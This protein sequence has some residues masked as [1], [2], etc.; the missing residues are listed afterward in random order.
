MDVI[1][2]S[3]SYRT[4]A[5][6]VNAGFTGTVSADHAADTE[7]RQ[8]N[9][10]LTSLNDVV[11]QDFYTSF[12]KVPLIASYGV[13]A[14]ELTRSISP[15]R[16]V[17]V[18]DLVT[19][20]FDST[21]PVAG[22]QPDTP[23]AVRLAG[24]GGFHMLVFDL[25]TH[26]RF[27]PTEVATQCDLVVELLGRHGV[28]HVV[29][30]SGPGGG[31]HIWIGLAEP[32][33]AGLVRDVAY[34]IRAITPALDIS[35]LTNL[36]EGCCR[37][38]GTPHRAGGCSR[39]IAGD[40][41][42]LLNPLTTREQIEALLGEVGQLPRHVRAPRVAQGVLWDVDD[43]EHMCIPGG[44][45]PLPE[46]VQALAETPVG[47]T[48][49][50][51]AVLW[52]VLVSA[53]LSHWRW[54]DVAGLLGAP[55]FEHVRTMRISDTVRRP[56]PPGEPIRVLARQWRRA[57]TYASGLDRSS[58]C[59]DASFER[60]QQLVVALVQEAIGRADSSPGR[61]QGQR[62]VRDRKVLTVVWMLG[63]Q[64]VTTEPQIDVRRM[65]ELT[66][67][68]RETARKALRSLGDDGWLYRMSPAVEQG[69]G[70]EADKYVIDPASVI[71]RDGIAGLSKA[72]PGGRAAEVLLAEFS[73]LLQ[74]AVH[75]VFT[76][77]QPHRGMCGLGAQAGWIWARLL[78]N[79]V[80]A[81]P[82]SPERG[83]MDPYWERLDENGLIVH[84]LTGAGD[85]VWLATDRRDQAAVELGCSGVLTQR[86][87]RHRVE[88]NVWV[89][90]LADQHAHR[91]GRAA[92]RAWRQ[93]TSPPVG[94]RSPCPP[95]PTRPD[96]GGLDH[97]VATATVRRGCLGPDSTY[98][99]F[100]IGFDW[101][102][103]ERMASQA[104]I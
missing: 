31:R 78:L 94:P 72:L 47:V 70:K 3:P 34:G 58:Q 56:R 101:V 95:F 6:Q 15:S 64:G 75:D 68:S 83:C 98:T 1:S 49:D 90:L 79:D 61:W 32:L 88:R 59:G 104:G 27:T 89:W 21:A 74:A 99:E 87:A 67:T 26:G 24:L 12:G 97:R 96:T 51:S 82:R 62:G 17:R 38:P 55:G 33:P 102:R 85:S 18:V 44:R 63:L 11:D 92:A 50:A 69:L 80:P 23:W 28:E 53:A 16:W 77:P 60:R 48:V 100:E 91:A 7:S 57:V 76:H 35:P 25:D 37:L 30:E 29:C 40:V 43:S 14:W 5:E 103:A 8:S 19:G 4:G 36:R 86:H 45:R 13:S 93:A 10:G 52:R 41:G 54:S 71:H 65:A 39:V 84:R 81:R 20:R 9:N 46:R 73:Q 42:V 66:G 2:L 22:E